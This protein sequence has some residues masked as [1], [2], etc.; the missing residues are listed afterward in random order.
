MKLF[1][2]KRQYAD[3]VIPPEL[4]PYYGPTKSVWKERFV[5]YRVPIALVL[6]A[7]IILVSGLIWWQSRSNDDGQVQ[8]K[9][10]AVRQSPQKN[11]DNLTV[12]KPE[13]AKEPAKAP[14]NTTPN[15]TPITPP[16]G[17]LPAVGD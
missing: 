13:G 11:D 6:L 15:T 17:S 10:P 4:K 3:P 14:G 8:V 1:R 16:S 5:R 12:P 2:T 7:L 9:T